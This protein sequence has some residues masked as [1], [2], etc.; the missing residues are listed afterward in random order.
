MLN[1]NASTWDDA[2]R[3]EWLAAGSQLNPAV[4]VFEKIDDAQIEAQVQRLLDTKKNNE[5]ADAEAAAGLP[6]K[7]AKPEITYEDFTKMDIRVA[8]IL[9][10]EK[11]PKTT[12]LM[13][14]KVDT[15]L[16]Q[17]TLVAGIAEHFKPEEVIGRKICIL[18]N[19]QSRKLKGI[20]SKG[21]ILMAEDAGGQLFFVSTDEGCE[22]G[23]TVK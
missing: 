6:L 11:I 12:K 16:D 17:R 22:N 23:S 5:S 13:R 15:G 3:L 4:Y 18:A 21:M 14:L 7:P 20:E 1:L 2:T 9:E 8:M 19:L 10:A